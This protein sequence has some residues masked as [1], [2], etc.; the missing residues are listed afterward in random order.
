MG[1]RKA[2]ELHLIDGTKSRRG[3]TQL[4]PDSVKQRIPKAYWIDNPDLWDKDRFIEETA[5]FLYEVYGIGTEQDQ[6]IMAFLVQQIELYIKCQKGIESKGVLSS[7]NNGKTIGPNPYIA[8]QKKTLAQII[9]IMNE[10][11]LTARG[12]LSAG[13]T[14]AESPMAKF[15][16]GPLAG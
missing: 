7:Y 15:L 4:L 13:K 10:M 11:G 12:R 3:N 2:P 9:Q 8:I 14:E 6:H 16:A 5:E 1:N